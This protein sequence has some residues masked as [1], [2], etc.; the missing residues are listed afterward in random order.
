MK[1]LKLLTIGTCQFYW[2]KISLIFKFPAILENGWSEEDFVAI[3]SFS[4]FPIVPLVSSLKTKYPAKLIIWFL[5]GS[6]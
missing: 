6:K 3:W 5:Q 1:C 4:L 2:I